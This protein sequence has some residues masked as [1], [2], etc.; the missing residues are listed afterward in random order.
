MLGLVRREGFAI[1][2][3]PE[4]ADAIIVNTCGFIR[5]AVREGIAAVIE[6]AGYKTSGACKALIVTG[7]MVTRYKDDILAEL[8][9]VDA[10]LGTRELPRIV[11]VIKRIF[12]GPASEPGADESSEDLYI[13]RA[14]STHMGYAYLKIAEGCDN[15]CT[16]CAIPYIKGPH[17]SR[18]ADSLLA[19][20]ANLAAQGVRELVLVAQDTTM[21]GKDIYGRPS[22]D[23]LLRKLS[24][25]PEIAWL[26]VMYAYPENITEA[27]ITEIAE[28]NKI[29]KYLDMPVQHASDSVLKRMGRKSAETELRG[30]I[31][32]LRETIPGIALRT[33][34]MTGFPGETQRDFKILRNFVEDMR[35]EHLGAFTFSRE[36]GV[37]AY[38]MK[39]HLPEK[40]KNDRRDILLKKQAGISLNNNKQFVAQTLTVLT[41]GR[42]PDEENPQGCLYC[43]RSYRDCPEND[44]MVFFHSDEEIMSGDFVNVLIS[45]AGEHDLYGMRISDESS[46]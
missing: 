44:G 20:A 17:K 39:G 3:E 43:G 9:E 23:I 21:Y 38:T 27:L 37:P 31:G 11:D 10:I 6:L 5:A 24:D 8:P 32:R 4:T 2:N 12:N 30:L 13:N 33:T 25:I 34:I 29:C 14:L 19:E 45:E 42:V 40:L 41:E 26:R 16:Y 22:L 15:R 28:N 1:V 18:Q 7:C 36:E 46:Q 35:F